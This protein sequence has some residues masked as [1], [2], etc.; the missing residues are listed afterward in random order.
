MSRG[1]LDSAPL[2][3]IDGV[4]A[5]LEIRLAVWFH[6]YVQSDTTLELTVLL[7]EEVV[8]VCVCTR[9]SE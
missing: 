3:V 9:V 6:V 4:S 2:K 7:V 5:S 1:Y 8:C